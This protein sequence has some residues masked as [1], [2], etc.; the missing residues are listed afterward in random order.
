MLMENLVGADGGDTDADM[1]EAIVE[2][3]SMELGVETGFRT[4]CGAIANFGP[5]M[6]NEAHQVSWVKDNFRSR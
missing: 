2:F 3:A 4:L 1:N 6:L 5:E